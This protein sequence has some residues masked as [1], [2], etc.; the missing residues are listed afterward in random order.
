MRKESKPKPPNPPVS[1]YAMDEILLRHL[2][3]GEKLVFGPWRPA[4]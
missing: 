1:P 3:G 2:Y 4:F